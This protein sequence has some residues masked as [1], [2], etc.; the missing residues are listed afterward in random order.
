MESTL[1]NS[2]SKIKLPE[3]V[4][5]FSTLSASNTQSFVDV[6]MIEYPPVEGPQGTLAKVIDY[7]ILEVGYYENNE[8][9]YFTEPKTVNITQT[10]SPIEITIE[11]SNMHPE[12]S[13]VCVY[14]TAFN[15][16]T[17][18]TTWSEEGCEL[19]SVSDA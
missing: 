18:I 6:R 19:G 9:S 2:L 8:V 4:L 16:T 7:E 13:P 11:V 12:Y 14:A 5:D 1:P 3:G 15:E 10:T 17:G